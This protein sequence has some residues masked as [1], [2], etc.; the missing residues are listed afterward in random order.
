VRR[1]S[2][3]PLAHAGYSS[4][5]AW[6]I[7]KRGRFLDPAL[8]RSHSS[9][10]SRRSVCEGSGNPALVLPPC[11]ICVVAQVAA[12][13]HDDDLLD[14]QRPKNGVPIELASLASPMMLDAAA[15]QMHRDE[16]PRG[17]D[18]AARALVGTPSRGFGAFDVDRIS[19]PTVPFP[20]SMSMKFNRVHGHYGVLGWV[21]GVSMQTRQQQHRNKNKDPNR[22]SSVYG[23][24]QYIR[25]KDRVDHHRRLLESSPR[26]RE[27][28]RDGS[29]AA[30]LRGCNRLYIFFAP[31]QA[32]SRIMQALGDIDCDVFIKMKR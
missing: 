32:R 6:S 15:R 9:I 8:A 22:E 19:S 18:A 4:T 24:G 13:K 28:N 25:E 23:F 1:G 16:R 17:Q 5:S 10:P 14:Q 27:L 11:D 7:F 20:F 30:D 3:A 2:S 21:V 29:G 26:W 31:S 12:T